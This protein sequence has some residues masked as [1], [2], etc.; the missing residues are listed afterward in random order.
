[1]KPE[2]YYFRFKGSDVHQI[3]NDI[4][5]VVRFKPDG[6]IYEDQITENPD[7]RISYEP[8]SWAESFTKEEAKTIQF[9]TR[10]DIFLE[11]I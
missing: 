1:M 2:Q 6:T 11:N 3:V 5:Y 9:L 10:D 4:I 7:D 8:E